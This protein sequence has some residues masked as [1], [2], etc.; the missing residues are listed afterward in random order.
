V[1]I[2]KLNIWNPIDHLRAFGWMLITPSKFNDYNSEH[3]KGSAEKIKS[4]VS[5]T[6]TMFPLLLAFGLWGM[7]YVSLPEEAWKLPS[8]YLYG[9]IALVLCWILLPILFLSFSN[10]K[11]A[12]PMLIFIF[13]SLFN[14]GGGLFLALNSIEPNFY[15]TGIILFGI[16]AS[17]SINL[18]VPPNLDDDGLVYLLIAFSIVLGFAVV[19]AGFGV[20]EIAIIAV[21]SL[22]S[23]F[24]S[25]KN[26]NETVVFLVFLAILLIISTYLMT[27]TVVSHFWLVDVWWLVIVKLLG[28]LV[29]FVLVSILVIAGYSVLIYYSPKWLK[30]I[31]FS[32]PYMFWGLLITPNGWSWFLGFF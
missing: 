6:I 19:F 1:S 23:I 22:I 30:P 14:L 25:S 18:Y 17:A 32:L 8:A 11:G 26:N 27:G 13:F 15:I 24:S 5:R 3:G 12:V 7:S 10:D 21:I 4:W 29:F 28:R 16:F 31:L 2:K 9:F 20:L